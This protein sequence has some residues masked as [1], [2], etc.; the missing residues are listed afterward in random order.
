MSAFPNPQPTNFANQPPLT[1]RPNEGFAAAPQQAE[2]PDPLMDDELLKQSALDPRGSREIAPYGTF[3]AVEQG[4]E[5]GYYTGLEALD[6]G[7]MPDGTPAVLF[8]D[9]AGQRQAIRLSEQQWLAALQQ[10]SQARI[11][12]AMQMRKKRDADRLRAPIRQ[13]AQELE[14][15]APGFNM[16]AESALERDPQGAYTAVQEMYARVQAKDDSVIQAMTQRVNATNLEVA[17]MQAESFVNYKT[18]QYT[19]QLEGVMSDDSIPD[20][21]KAQMDQHLR[22]KLLNLQQFGVYAPPDGSVVGA[23]A[24]PSYYMTTGNSNALISMADMAIS[25]LGRDAIEAMP[26]ELRIP[27]L[28]QRAEEMTRQVGWGRP[29]NPADRDIAAKYIAQRLG[30]A[31]MASTGGGGMRPIYG[32]TQE[33]G[34]QYANAPALEASPATDPTRQRTLGGM[35]RIQ[36]GREEQAQATEMQQAKLASERAR[37]AGA[38]AGARRSEASAQQTEAITGIIT[39]EDRK[40]YAELRDEVSALG[41]DMPDSGDPVSDIIEASKQLAADTSREGR[42]RYAKFV[43]LLVKYRK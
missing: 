19:S 38:L 12:M 28:A 5:N 40:Q 35:A 7:T 33:M 43:A 29:W 32:P 23:A 10:R 24:F 37:A 34:M 26:P 11:G 21:Y 16:F 8:T 2:Q 22:I 20:Y 1:L 3:G 4:L 42:A 6:F 15:Y 25:D 17:R 30:P 36:A 27:T 41:Y 14:A 39:E 9:K 18:D 13:M 31:V